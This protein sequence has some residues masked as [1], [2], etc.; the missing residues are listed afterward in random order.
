MSLHEGSTLSMGRS[1]P[2]KETRISGRLFS[3]VAIFHPGSSMA[4]L[5]TRKDLVGFFK[6]I[7]GVV[8]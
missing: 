4:D 1:N 5:A 3:T 6:C 8:I 7:F 2:T